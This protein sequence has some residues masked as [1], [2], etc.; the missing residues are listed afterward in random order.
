MSSNDFI[1]PPQ[2]WA[3]I[4]SIAEA[5]R[6]YFGMQNEPYLNVMD[7]IERVLDQEMGEFEFQVEDHEYMGNAE[8]YTDPN[9]E[10]IILRDDVYEAAV[11]G[12]GR[13]RFTAAH[14]LAHWLLHRDVKLARIKPGQTIKPYQSA[15]AQANR[16]A[17][18]LLMP[19][20][21][22]TL[23]DTV[24]EIAKRHGVSALAA[25]HQIHHLTKK[26]NIGK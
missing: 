17:A 7:L 2:S 20:K 16:M 21:F 3:N 1:V 4:A 9:G 14:E 15:E 19:A 10:F 24:D 18:D 23:S 25:K 8:G 11:A 26:G 22:F 5:V 13:A 6:E 12:Q